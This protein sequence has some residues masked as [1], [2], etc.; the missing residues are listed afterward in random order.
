MIKDNLRLVLIP[1]LTV[2]VSIIQKAATSNHLNNWS[3]D[4]VKEE[5]T[6]IVDH[7]FLRK[8]VINIS[9]GEYFQVKSSA[10]SLDCFLQFIDNKIVKP[11][12]AGLEG[13]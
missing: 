10:N 9:P 13:A 5:Y 11:T 6:K 2:S 12:Y 1:N 4:F 7:K 3:I 8:T